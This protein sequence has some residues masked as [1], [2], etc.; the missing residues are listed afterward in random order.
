MP[1]SD[2]MAY[3]VL[4]TPEADKMVYQ[5]M[6]TPEANETASH[7]LVPARSR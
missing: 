2:K 6:F 1:E 3:Q 7:I 4:F 5:F